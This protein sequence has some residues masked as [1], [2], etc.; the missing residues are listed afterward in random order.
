MQNEC[1]KQN[2]NR[3]HE[4]STFKLTCFSITYFLPTLATHSKGF[5][6]SF[7][8]HSTWHHFQRGHENI[9]LCTFLPISETLSSFG[10]VPASCYLDFSE[11]IRPRTH[12]VMEMQEYFLAY[13]S[14]H[15]WRQMDHQVSI[16]LVRPIFFCHWRVM[17]VY[18]SFTASD[19]TVVS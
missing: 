16:P 6:C 17:T 19:H 10:L 12:A 9:P 18:M 4:I 11:V 5:V 8:L 14:W 15:S 7:K 1:F 3:S 13:L 2:F